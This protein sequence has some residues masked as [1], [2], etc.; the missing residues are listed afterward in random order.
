MITET[1]RPVNSWECY[2]PDIF[3]LNCESC[4]LEFAKDNN[5]QL[6]TDA[7]SEGFGIS[8]CWACGHETDYPLSC[9]GCGEYLAGNLTAEG[10]EYLKE[11]KFPKWLRD[12][13]LSI[14]KYKYKK[15]N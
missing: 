1:R 10:V 8:E 7:G 3:F 12:Y 4:A 14:P 11:R 9:D 5:I 2:T 15:G 13:Y 6:D